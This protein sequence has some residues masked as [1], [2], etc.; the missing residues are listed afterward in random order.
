[1]IC[2]GGRGRGRE[3]RVLDHT[4]L[5]YY[6]ADL[7][8]HSRLTLPTK[9]LRGRVVKSSAESK[10]ARAMR[11]LVRRDRGIFIMQASAMQASAISCQSEF[12][13][14]S[15]S[16]RHDHGR[17]HHTHDLLPYSSGGAGDSLL[18]AG[19][20]AP[21]RPGGCRRSHTAAGDSRVHHRDGGLCTYTAIWEREG[22]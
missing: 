14:R 19:I 10:N 5:L 21:G 15:H 18:Q 8:S 16:Q 12:R 6:L 17:T 20:T 2:R 9:Y 22:G 4:C 1:M 7:V 11:F 13:F 3:R